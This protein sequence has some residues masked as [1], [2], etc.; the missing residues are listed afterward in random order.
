[1]KRFVFALCVMLAAVNAQATPLQLSGSLDAGAFLF[2]AADNNAGCANGTALV[3]LNP[4]IGILDLGTV[5][6]GGLTVEGSLHTDTFGGPLNILNSSSLTIRNNTSVAISLQSTISA[7]DFPG[8]TT[9]VANSG[10]G[11]WQGAAGSTATYSFYLDPV[12]GVGGQTATDR[13]GVL[14][15]S[16][17]DT[18]V[19]VVDSFSTNFGPIAFST[20]GPF[21]MSLGFDMNL[22]GGGQLIS[23][24]QTQVT[25]VQAV[26]EP[27]SL[28]LL[29]IGLAG[30]G[31]RFRRSHK[32]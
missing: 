12:N 11:T 32:A 22:L 5:N 4:T 20:A 25:D 7:D 14:I 1:M 8:E 3:D 26:P 6:I 15:S 28:V 2:C 24:G 23:R 27:A 17:S 18:A 13:P 30:L 9:F 31:A 29:G 19:G 16:F 21:S 10:S